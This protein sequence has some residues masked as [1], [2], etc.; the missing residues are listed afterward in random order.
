MSVLSNS[1][2]IH[3]QDSSNQFDVL[4]TFTSLSTKEV[5]GDQD[6]VS[7]QRRED[8][9]KLLSQQSPSTVIIS[10][11]RRLTATELKYVHIELAPN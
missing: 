10:V 8:M 9:E 4:V 6:N 11:C 5:K 7:G 2:E 3:K 1:V